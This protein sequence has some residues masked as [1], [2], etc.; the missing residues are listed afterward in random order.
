MEFSLP[1]ADPG[2]SDPKRYVFKVA[3]SETMT[4]VDGRPVECWIVTGDYN[5]GNVRA[6]FWFDKKTQV[7]L[8][9]EAIASEDGQQILVKTLLGE[10]Q[11]DRAK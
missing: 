4:G 10:E 7:M 9:E 6:R 3:G 8:H 5:T 1:F 2:L 11:A